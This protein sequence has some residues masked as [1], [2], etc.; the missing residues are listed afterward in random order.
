MQ[1]KGKKRQPTTHTHIDDLAI[2]SNLNR[3]V[4]NE[5]KVE[6]EQYTKLTY[7]VPRRSF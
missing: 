5:Y 2:L 1:K 7:F 3:S 6:E 4:V